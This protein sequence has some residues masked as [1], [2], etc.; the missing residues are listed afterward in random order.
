[1]GK[2]TAFIY[3]L[4]RSRYKC[5]RVRQLVFWWLLPTLG[6]SFIFFPLPA[7]NRKY[8]PPPPLKPQ[9]FRI[10][11]WSLLLLSLYPVFMLS[12]SSVSCNFYAFDVLHP[13]ALSY[14]IS[15]SLNLF[16]LSLSFTHP[17]IGSQLY[18]F[19]GRYISI[20]T[21]Y[22]LLRRLFHSPSFLLLSPL[23]ILL[24]IRMSTHASRYTYLLLSKQPLCR[25]LAELWMRSCQVVD[26]I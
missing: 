25:D 26:E 18:P 21:P 16:C 15:R 2:I 9:F 13:F 19:L 10:P 7:T 14:Q 4:C 12:L 17:Y 5:M 3:H 6:H 22:V 20:R 8:P 11:P 24:Y 1:M 23:Y